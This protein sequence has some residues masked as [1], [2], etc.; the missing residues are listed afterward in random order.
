MAQSV[1]VSDDLY[2]LAQKASQAL[3]RP[4]AQQMEYWARLGAALDAAG[5][6]A[7]A[8]M[9]LLGNG[10]SADDF[11]KAALGLGAPADGGLQTLKDVQRKD[12]EDVKAGRRSA[13]S[14]WAV[15]KG[16]LKGYIFTPSKT[17]EF[18]RVGNGW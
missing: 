1:R 4:L 7:A 18:D 8:A 11:V 17:S 16:G 5:I 3:S 14:L 13:R 10:A 6:S 2:A 9:E 15:Q 12:A